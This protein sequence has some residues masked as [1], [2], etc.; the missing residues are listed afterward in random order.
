M[1]QY[2][3]RTLNNDAGKIRMKHINILPPSSLSLALIWTLLC[4]CLC[5]LCEPFQSITLHQ[6]SCFHAPLLCNHPLLMSF[7]QVSSAC[8]KM[9]SSSS[10]WN[11]LFFLIQSKAQPVYLYFH[12]HVSHIF[13]LSLPTHPSNQGTQG[14]WPR[15]FQKP[16]KLSTLHIH[17]TYYVLVHFPKALF[18][19]VTF[20]LE[21]CWWLSIHSQRV[22]STF[23]SLGQDPPP[24]SNLIQFIWLYFLLLLFTCPTFQPS[25][26]PVSS[27]LF[28]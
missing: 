15:L 2:S 1:A 13:L 22:T 19:D 21:N 27:P 24:C 5:Q 12:I 10:P 14:A 3:F 8:P 18:C 20:L 26:S 28:M 25:F 6:A 9:N 16:L 4:C 7:L 11:L 17:P 23:L